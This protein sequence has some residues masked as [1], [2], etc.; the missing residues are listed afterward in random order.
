MGMTLGNGIGYK[1][2]NKKPMIFNKTI[3]FFWKGQTVQNKKRHLDPQPSIGRKQA[4]KV[5]T[6]N[7]GYFLWKEEEERPRR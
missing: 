1:L 2:I 5:L 7:M 3:D 6:H 4:E